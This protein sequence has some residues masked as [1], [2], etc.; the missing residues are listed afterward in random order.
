[1]V[2]PRTF[3]LVH[4][5][6]LGEPYYSDSSVKYLEQTLCYPLGSKRSQRQRRSQSPDGSH[7]EQNVS[8]DNAAA[9]SYPL[10]VLSGL[11][12]SERARVMVR[13]WSASTR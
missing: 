13:A 2:L 6:L 8:G 4:H 3:R 12:P 7:A 5:G 1:M 9:P 11:P 10:P